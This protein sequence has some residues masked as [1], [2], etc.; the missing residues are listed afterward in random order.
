MMRLDLNDVT[1]LGTRQISSNVLI[2]VSN[3]SS[4]RTA[5][6]LL[7][8]QYLS[9]LDSVCIPLPS[10]PFLKMPHPL[11]KA[12]LEVTLFSTVYYC[13]APCPSTQLLSARLLA[14]VGL[15]RMSG[16]AGCTLFF[17]LQEVQVAFALAPHL[18][19]LLYNRSSTSFSVNGFWVAL[20]RRVKG[21]DYCASVSSV[22]DVS[23][24]VDRNGQNYLAK[25]TECAWAIHRSREE[26]GMSWV[27][28]RQLG[29][30]QIPYPSGQKLLRKPERIQ[31]LCQL[32]TLPSY[33]FVAF[34]VQVFIEKKVN[35]AIFSGVA[36]FF[37]LYM[38]ASW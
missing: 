32:M 27:V 9:L 36:Y 20:P 13:L 25:R 16:V 7:A 21:S 11:Q 12:R 34:Q 35:W 18:I 23:R 26:D 24:T 4:F 37:G 30:F 17:F 19:W 28:N 10:T 14:F 33:S 38:Y 15:D 5:F 3:I 29:E 8:D 6:L 1:T 22:E 31:I 2:K